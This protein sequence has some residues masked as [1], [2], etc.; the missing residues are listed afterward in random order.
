MACPLDCSFCLY[1]R[2]LLKLGDVSMPMEKF[3][4]LQSK[5][6][7]LCAALIGYIS[8]WAFPHR[9]DRRMPLMP[10]LRGAPHNKLFHDNHHSKSWWTNWGMKIPLNKKTNLEVPHMPRG[11]WTCWHCFSHHDLVTRRASQDPP[12]KKTAYCTN[13]KWYLPWVFSP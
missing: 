9:G 6:E 10:G 7:T 12:R 13:L 11:P 5:R 8:Y 1:S 2:I 3:Q 4:L